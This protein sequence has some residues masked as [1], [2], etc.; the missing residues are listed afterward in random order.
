MSDPQTYAHRAR[1]AYVEAHGGAEAA[2]RANSVLI[3]LHAYAA[4]FPEALGRDVVE[5]FRTRH[6]AAC[7]ALGNPNRPPSST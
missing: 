2:A 7:E 5:F 6:A 1:Q 4:M 3:A